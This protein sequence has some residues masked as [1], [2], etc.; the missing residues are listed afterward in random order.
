MTRLVGPSVQERLVTRA[1]S[2]H[3]FPVVYLAGTGYSGSTLLSFLFDA[4][5][6]VVSVGEFPAPRWETPDYECSCGAKLRECPFFGHVA[7]LLTRGG[8]MFNPGGM[9]LRLR[10][11]RI[12]LL[13]RVLVANLRSRSLTLSRDRL[14]RVIPGLMDRLDHY[15][16]RNEAFI[17]AALEVAGARVFFDANKTHRRL[18][19]LKRSRRIALKVIHLIRDPRA[20]SN[21]AVRHHPGMS[22]GAAAAAWVRV[23]KAIEWYVADLPE[24]DK[25]RLRYEDFCAQ[26]ES[27]YRR[28]CDFMGVAPREPP[29]RLQT[30]AHHIIGNPMRTTSDREVFV[31]LDTRWRTELPASAQREVMRRAGSLA[32]DYGYGD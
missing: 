22:V 26:P 24:E 29:M 25:A 9:D 13:N 11:T 18:P 4:H 19:L 21:S 1:D 23:H 15:V 7:A 28:L 32:R 3:P 14:V 5:P 12:P 8:V 6:D 31:R 17:Q 20:Q 16:A 10:Y 2:G 27:E 30:T